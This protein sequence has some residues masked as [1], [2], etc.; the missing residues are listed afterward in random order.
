M[1]RVSRRKRAATQARLYA[2]AQERERIERAKALADNTA[3]KPRGSTHKQAAKALAELEA[4]RV[5]RLRSDDGRTSKVVTM[6]DLKRKPAADLKHKRERQ[7]RGVTKWA[8][9]RPI[10]HYARAGYVHINGQYVATAGATGITQ[11]FSVNRASEREERH[12]REHPE[13]R[14][15]GFPR[16]RSERSRAKQRG[17]ETFARARAIF[18]SRARALKADRL[19]E[20]ARREASAMADADLRASRVAH[21]LR[22]LG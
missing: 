19:A 5:A 14:E 16:P 3:Y 4:S 2:E 22:H 15:W 21:A 18:A 8:N 11:I 13:P 10:L 12:A 7:L 20:R 6:A 1:A 17:R 9:G